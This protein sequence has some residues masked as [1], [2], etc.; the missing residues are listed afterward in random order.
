ML[1]GNEHY[2]NGLRTEAENLY[3]TAVFQYGN[4]FFEISQLML[5]FTVD[6]VRTVASRI[7][8]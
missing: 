5:K 8:L 3:C 1:N 2:N 7:A 4:N 6:Q